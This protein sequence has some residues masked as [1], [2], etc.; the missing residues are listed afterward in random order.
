MVSLTKFRIKNYKSINDS[1]EVYLSSDNITVLAG[2]NE[3][4]KTSVLEALEDFN[5]GKTIRESARPISSKLDPE[6]SLFFKINIEEVKKIKEMPDLYLKN[7]F[8]EDIELEVKKVGSNYFLESNDISECLENYNSEIIDI[9]VEIE[10]EINYIGKHVDVV[11]PTVFSNAE[12]FRKLMDQKIKDG[13]SKIE[14]FEEETKTRL[15]AL[16]DDAKKY[17]LE[18]SD[19]DE[20]IKKYIENVVKKEYI[21][22]F[23]IFETYKD[24]KIPNIIPFANL[25]TDEFIKDLQKVSN[26]DINLIKSTD[27]QGKKNHNGAINLDLQKD[28]GKY[29]TQSESNLE[30]TWDN[31]NVEFW[32]KEDNTS[33]MPEQ[34]SKGKQ[35]HLA[36]Y[37]RITARSKEGKNN[38]LLI[39]EPGLFLHA[40]AQED[41]IHKLEDASSNM[42]I[43][44]TTHSPYLLKEL[45]RIKLVEWD[46]KKGTKIQNKCWANSKKDTIT[47]ILT[48]IGE[49]MAGGLRADKKN[50]FVV[51]GITD[52]LYIQAFKKLFD[53]KLDFE[54]IPGCGK[55][56]PSIASILV[57]WKLDP[58]FIFDKDRDGKGYKKELTEKLLIPKDRFLFIL[59]Q[60]D[61][62]IEDVFAEVDFKKLVLEDE[63]AKIGKSLSTYLKKIGKSKTI[64][65]QNFLNNVDKGKIS[66]DDLSKETLKNVDRI[67]NWISEKLNSANN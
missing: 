31:N 37:I 10:N 51:E 24:S 25:E 9:I 11:F 16:F 45:H 40:Q 67:F 50:S 59:D 52:Y 53:S 60:D 44:Y 64:L 8:S 20:L 62:D 2:M 57:G 15:N 56:I 41:I 27:R 7:C 6:I 30:I 48:A 66:K 1:G 19:Y 49:N 46:E 42:G 5:V 36:F 43:I 34:R 28:Y 55:N 23:I 32:V 17:A 14:D 33:Y 38:I 22:N 13:K 4:G 18:F 3:S 29:W 21:P 58:F 65:A 63:S 39:D 47:P 26:L 61:K 35:W 12:E 54:M